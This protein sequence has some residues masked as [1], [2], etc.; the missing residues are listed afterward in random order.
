MDWFNIIRAVLRNIYLLISPWA[1]IVL[2]FIVKYYKECII[3]EIV[4]LFGTLIWEKIQKGKV[5][6][7]IWIRW[8][9]ALLPMILLA[10]WLN[11]E[12]GSY[13]E[14]QAVCS[15]YRDDLLI[16]LD[17]IDNT[18][19]QI[20]VAD[21]ILDNSLKSANKAKANHDKTYYNVYWI[22]YQYEA[23][24]HNYILNEKERLDTILKG[25]KE[26]RNKLYELLGM[27]CLAD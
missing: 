19:K 23:S 10:L 16:I 12:I 25:Q 22:E 13:Q 11:P 4:T 5:E 26:Q 20:K 7:C 6:K 3:G 15:E 24:F 21:R 17:E 8:L 14:L 2:D 1:S 9:V 27:E 18:N